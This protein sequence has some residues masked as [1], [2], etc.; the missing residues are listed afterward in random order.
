MRNIMKQSMKAYIN[1]LIKRKDLMKYLVVS[2]LKAQH[3]DSYLGF[4]WWLLDPLLQ[5][6]IYYF[7][8][9]YIFHQAKGADYG[10]YLAT[11]LMVWRWLTSSM[12]SSVRSITSQASIITQV[13]LPKATFPICT[14]V[15]QMVNFGFGLMVIA[16]CFIFFHIKPG[17]ASLWLPFIVGVQFLFMLAISLAVAYAS[18]FIRD[19]EMIMGH[20]LRFWFYG[21]P[22]IWYADRMPESAKWL[23]TF[24]PMACILSGY[25]NMIIHNSAPDYSSLLIIGCTSSMLIF[26][27]MY[28][29]NQY[30]H[31]II[32]AL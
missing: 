2:G 16:I 14:V 4:F 30:E 3:K 32:R 31:K 15:S 19:I 7:V 6:F 21:T 26:L 11:G 5:I 12:T 24:N 28:I 29:Y 17:I 23:L 25:R 8:V 20:I 10:I 27:L 13:Y 1:E 18:I 22:V 9:V